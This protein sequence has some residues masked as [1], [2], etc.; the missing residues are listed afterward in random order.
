MPAAASIACDVQLVK[1][2]SRYIPAGP[3][4]DES[5]GVATGRNREGPPR[6]A[7]IDCLKELPGADKATRLGGDHQPAALRINEVEADAEWL[8]DG[9]L[10][11]PPRRATVCRAEDP[12]RLRAEA[13]D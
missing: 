2:G 7:A 1:A 6:H 11:R 3:E 12:D 10:A 8:V 4:I 13:T 5:D 9:D